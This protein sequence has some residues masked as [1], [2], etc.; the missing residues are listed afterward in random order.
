MKTKGVSSIV[1]K[2]KLNGKQ[3]KTHLSPLPE[4]K[5]SGVSQK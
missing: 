4:K 5:K 1:F 3:K 2:K